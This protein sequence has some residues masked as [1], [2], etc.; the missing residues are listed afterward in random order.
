MEM[1]CR[2]KALRKIKQTTQEQVAKDLQISNACYARYE[3][4]DRQ[5]NP[6]MIVKLAEYFDC[7]TDYL[8]GKDRV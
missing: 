8:L 4:N 6:D 3:T 7:T 1:G 2:L 5:P